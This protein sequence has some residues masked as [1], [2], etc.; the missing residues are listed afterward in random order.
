[1][2]IDMEFP[3]FNSKALSD[4]K[5]YNLT[6]PS[7]RRKYFESKLGSKI[8]DLKEYLEANSF[9]G[10]MLARKMA[11]KGTYAKM[12]EEIL[13]PDRVTSISVGD[14]VRNY[15][16]L[17]ENEENSKKAM[18]EL[19]KYYRGFLGRRGC[20]FVGKKAGKCFGSD[21]VNFSYVKA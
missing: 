13:G 14:I 12:V 18:T 6:D 1:L 4:G 19:A 3:I 2:I 16:S 10:Y 20:C 9:V 7:E 21:G 15:H 11:G 17:F 5:S 8:S